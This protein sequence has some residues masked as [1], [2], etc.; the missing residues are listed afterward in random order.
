M[1]NFSTM[2]I[3]I[4]DNKPVSGDYVHQIQECFKTSHNPY[5]AF[6]QGILS[7]IVD[8]NETVIWACEP[9]QGDHERTFEVEKHFE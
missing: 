9:S 8:Y 4:I 6:K 2:T 7:W 5:S 1:D 3:K